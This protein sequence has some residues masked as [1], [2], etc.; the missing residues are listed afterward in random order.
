MPL[1]QIGVSKS[2]LG[3]ELPRR[4]AGGARTDPIGLEH[5]HVQAKP[6]EKQTGRHAGDAGTYDDNLGFVRSI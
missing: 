6:L 1:H 5:Y 4:P 3:G 2:V